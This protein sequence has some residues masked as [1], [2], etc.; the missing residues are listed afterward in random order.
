VRRV[1][2]FP[3][4]IRTASRRLAAAN[5]YAVNGPLTGCMGK[6][7]PVAAAVTP[8]HAGVH[9]DLLRVDSGFR[10]SPK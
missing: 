8:A 9:G 6:R 7:I 2:G 1:G 3:V 10:L 5:W 4:R